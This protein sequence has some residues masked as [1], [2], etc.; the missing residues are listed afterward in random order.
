MKALI[1]RKKRKVRK[2]KFSTVVEQS[3]ASETETESSPQR[4]LIRPMKFDGVGSF[5]TFMAHFR[6]CATHN[7]CNQ[8]EQLSWLKTVLLKMQARFCGIQAQKRPVHCKN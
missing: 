5:D 1:K 3:S 7:R 6:N 4:H 8:K 2:T